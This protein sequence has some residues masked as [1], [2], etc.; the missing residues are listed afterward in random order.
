MDRKELQTI[1]KENGIYQYQIA[2]RLKVSEATFVRWLRYPISE[3]LEQ[4]IRDAV[5]SIIRERNH[6]Q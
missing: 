3:E 2:D 4:R 6:E 1:C 5:V